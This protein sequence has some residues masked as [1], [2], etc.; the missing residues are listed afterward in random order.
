MLILYGPIV[1]KS[2][3]NTNFN[4][5]ANLV[6][7]AFVFELTSD[8]SQSQLGLVSEISQFLVVSQKE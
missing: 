8:L 1:S 2:E 4:L 5:R 7:F 3:Q 6:L